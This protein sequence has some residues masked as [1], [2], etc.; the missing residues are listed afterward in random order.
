MKRYLYILLATTAIFTACKSEVTIT[1]PPAPEIGFNFGTATTEVTESSAIID[2]FKPYIT[3]DGIRHDDAEIYLQY[4]AADNKEA[5]TTVTE[6]T[7]SAK[8]DNIIFTLEDLAD[9]TRYEFGITIA[10]CEYGETTNKESLYTFT[11]L[12]HIP[13]AAFDYDY[14]VASKG[15]LSTITL[16]DVAFTLDGE[17]QPIDKVRVEYQRQESELGAWRAIEKSGN[18]ISGGTAAFE[19]PAEGAEY[20][21]EDSN[22]IFR[23]TITPED[24]RYESYTSDN[25]QFK[26]DFA[27]VTADIATPSLSIE[28][29][30]I[31]A[32]VSSAKVYF[33]GIELSEYAYLDYYIYYRKAGRSEW[34][35]KHKVESQEDG[36]LT[37]SVDCA[38]LD[39]DATYEFCGV[40]VAGAAQ[41]VL[42][43]AVATIT[44]PKAETPAPPTP[45]APPVTGDADT[46]ELA[47]EWKLTSWRGAEPSFD[48]YLSITADGVVTLWQRLESRQWEVYYS[49]V[50]YENGI[51]TGLYTD[52]VAWGAVYSVSVA[53]DTMTWIDT[54]DATD[55]S[56]YTRSTL[57][58]S[59]PSSTSATRAAASERYL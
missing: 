47:G 20:L 13:A 54:A 36:S 44:T 12:E 26:T 22:Y 8:S 7:A 38:T 10:H 51:I 6:Y 18:D 58:N 16:R 35:E 2:I 14:E 41:Q 37:L 15:L 5:I 46:T 32:V 45:P 40:V 33:D 11:T 27:E 53:G 23:V 28:D 42:T 29:N 57:P 59:L 50:G 55:I 56:V 17:A 21:E 19:L 1:P 4:W 43:S 3:V 31:K 24:S 30:T 9:N 34:D 25:A 49:T 39:E 52:G 48:I